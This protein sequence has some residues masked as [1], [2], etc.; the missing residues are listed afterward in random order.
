MDPF[1]NIHVL[2][3]GHVLSGP[4]CAY[5][6][7]VLGADVIKVEPVDCPDI[8]RGRGPDDA[9]NAA[10][11][12]LTYQT[13]ASNKRAIAVDIKTPGGKSILARLIRG[14]DVF[15]ENY[16]TGALAELGFGYRDVRAIKKD[17]I[18]S[19]DVLNTTARIQEQCNQY[20]VDILIS[21]ETFDLI[22]DNDEFKLIPLG[23]I[24]L[25]GKKRKID[26]N[27]II[28]I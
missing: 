11:M 21:K 28:T 15:I 8:S 5:Q 19:G 25:R 6:L 18:Y 16:R 9:Q 23:S 2:E 12:G 1:D 26:L 10:G 14:A 17:I 27:T 7:A 13:Q 22:S 20:S 3:F 24:E 4:F